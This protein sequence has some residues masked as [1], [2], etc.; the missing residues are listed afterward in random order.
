MAPLFHCFHCKAGFISPQMAIHTFQS[1]SKDIQ[2]FFIQSSLFQ[3]NTFTNSLLSMDSSKFYE[4]YKIKCEAI[5]NFHF[6][7]LPYPRPL[8][9]KVVVENDDANEIL[10]FLSQMRKGR[11]K[12]DFYYAAVTTERA[13]YW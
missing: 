3:T 11:G 4:L 12:G 5:R 2:I 8:K 9:G 1:Q 7:F 10:R 13:G 6:S